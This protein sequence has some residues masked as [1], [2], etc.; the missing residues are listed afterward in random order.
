MY[1]SV[2][3]TCCCTLQVNIIVA[4]LQPSPEAYEVFD[5]IMLMGDAKVGVVCGVG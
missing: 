5:D 3:H 1:C 2:L 4:L